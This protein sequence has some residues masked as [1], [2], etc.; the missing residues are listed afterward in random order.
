MYGRLC[1]RCV[2]LLG[3]GDGGMRE[4]LGNRGGTGALGCGLD[5][6]WMDGEWRPDGW[7]RQ[8]LGKVQCSIGWSVVRMSGGGGGA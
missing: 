6:V 3:R 1:A 8:V 5:G 2:V 7:W 4:T